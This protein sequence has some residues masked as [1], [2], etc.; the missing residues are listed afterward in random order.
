MFTGLNNK[1]IVKRTIPYLILLTVTLLL[2]SIS[3]NY[4]F[5]GTWDDQGYVTDN[6]HI[7]LNFY[8]II[9]WFKNTLPVGGYTP[10]VMIS[11]MFDH[12]IGAYNPLVYHIHNILLHICVGFLL[13]NIFKLLR[14]NVFLSFF[15]TFLFLI[16]P[17]RVESVVWVS[18]RKDVLCATFYFLTIYLYLKNKGTLK[19]IVLIPFTCLL[20]LLSKPMA[21]SLPF[22][23]LFLE[24]YN[25]NKFGINIK[26]FKILIPC[27]LIMLPFP[28]LSILFQPRGITRF[29]FSH[30][31]YVALY[32]FYWYI[33]TTIFP[34][35]LSPFYPR[36]SLNSS[37]YEVIIFY[38]SLLFLF[39]FL[40]YKYNK[41]FYLKICPIFLCFFV[42]FLPIC[43][44]YRP[45]IKDYSDR[46]SY[47]PSFFLIVIIG[48]FLQ[49]FL[50]RRLFL[51]SKNILLGVLF[52]VF[53]IF[54]IF[55]ISQNISMQKK[56]KNKYTL[57]Q[58]VLDYTPPNVLI[59][60]KYGDIIIMNKDYTELYK[61]GN[62]LSK[63]INTDRITEYEKKTAFLASN[64]FMA[65]ALYHTNNKEKAL[66]FFKKIEN[67]VDDKSFTL[68]NYIK[69]LRMISEC[70]YLK[71]NVKKALFYLEILISDKNLNRF[72]KLYYTGMKY[73]Y[74]K[75]YDE[76]IK[77]FKNANKLDPNNKS[78]KFYLNICKKQK[79]VFI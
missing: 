21:V 6:K 68:I 35:N 40:A 42:S 74:L 64:F 18:Q 24:L 8:N 17:Q 46:F 1:K 53:L 54:S 48:L 26:R 67:G 20:A 70:Y 29:T 77:Y 16:H 38:F 30:E 44:L 66:N 59:L 51:L 10:L 3:W 13:F 73:Y 69:Y 58:S 33:T 39:I 27:F 47:I 5:L 28:F 76:A 52:I 72:A 12:S 19:F 78:S 49:R 2:Y 36:V 4:D 56:W 7:A 34:N 60:I 62:S 37:I 61:I 31:I 57:F 32:N 43:G 14:I 75:R 63:Q 50:N 22:I 23:L 11:F 45:A 15:L 79:S 65:Y 9:Y 41:Y 71:G 55:F 25:S